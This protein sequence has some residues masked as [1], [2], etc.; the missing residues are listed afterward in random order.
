VDAIEDGVTGVLVP[1]HSSNAL[2]VAIAD[3][4]DNA[5]KRQSMSEAASVFVRKNFD[6]G[7]MVDAL[8][9]FMAS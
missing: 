8:A 9:A 4:M 3:L 5:A 6:A 7:K 2:K 1:A